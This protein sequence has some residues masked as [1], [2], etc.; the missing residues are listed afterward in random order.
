MRL[1]LVLVLLCVAVFLY[2]LALPEKEYEAFLEYYGFSGKS[3][4]ERPYVVAT[5]VFLHA[6]AAHLLS[7]IFVLFFFGVA[8]EAEL[9]RKRML[10]IFFGGALAGDLLSLLVYPFDSLSVGASAAIFALIGAGMLVRPVDLSMYPLI[11]PIPLALLGIVY[12]VYNVYYFFFDAHS[13]ISYISH[14]GGL[15]VG[16]F[17]GAKAVGIK[18]SLAIL[19]VALVILLLIPIVLRYAGVVA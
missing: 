18:R 12:A 13:N 4:L 14:I 1:T 10:A 6:G 3:M 11:V 15:V 5:S 2:T 7:N 19:L 8:V 17:F 16:L 9:G